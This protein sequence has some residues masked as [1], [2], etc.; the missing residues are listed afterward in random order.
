M[1]IPCEGTLW[2]NLFGARECRERHSRRSRVTSSSNFFRETGAYIGR[3]MDIRSP[4]TLRFRA[5]IHTDSRTSTSVAVLGICDG[6]V[7]TAIWRLRHSDRSPRRTR[8][9]CGAT[10]PG[11]APWFIGAAQRTGR[12]RGGVSDNRSSRLF[13]GRAIPH[14]AIRACEIAGHP[15]TVFRCTEPVVMLPDRR[16]ACGKSCCAVGSSGSV[17]RR[18]MRVSPMGVINATEA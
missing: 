15:Q 17:G 11:H 14:R 16:H 9:A 12:T 8:L 1:V 13:R 7:P 18:P 10:L 4:A 5:P 6:P 3:R 2:T